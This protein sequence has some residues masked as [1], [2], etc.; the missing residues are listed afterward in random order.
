MLIMKKYIS[1]LA[2][3]LMI[4]P[5]ARRTGADVGDFAVGA[6]VSK[7]D[8]G[9]LSDGAED[10]RGFFVRQR[11]GENWMIETSVDF[12]N[13][14]FNQN[15]GIRE[16]D[17][18]EVTF[19]TIEDGFITSKTMKLPRIPD[20]SFILTG[21]VDVVIIWLTAYHFL[22]QSEQLALFV[23]GG[24]NY[25]STDY[26]YNRHTFTFNTWVQV[27][28][29]GFELFFPTFSDF[30]AIPSDIEL[31]RSVSTKVEEKLAPHV[32]VGIVVAITDFL[33]VTSSVLYRFDEGDRDSKYK[34]GLRSF[35]EANDWEMVTPGKEEI[36]LGGWSANVGV[37]VHF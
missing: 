30:E 22:A 36:N 33:N 14:S 1:L 12:Y 5:I 3:I 11:V 21:D 6:R 32:A 8:L 34:P 28:V 7:V 23:G 19:L 20:E 13:F 29:E 2:A 16:T 17:I 24:L 37:E 25:L 15:W 4:L 18:A 10:A 31:R 27:P 26:E 9:E 35:I